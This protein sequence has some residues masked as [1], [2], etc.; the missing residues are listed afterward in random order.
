MAAHIKSI[1]CQHLLEVSLEGFYNDHSS[2]H[3]GKEEEH[4][5]ASSHGCAT[6]C[7]SKRIEVRLWS[8]ARMQD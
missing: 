2:S 3:H 7:G 1:D 4:D 8:E 5:A 6:S